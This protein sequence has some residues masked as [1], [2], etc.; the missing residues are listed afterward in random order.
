MSGGVL[1]SG[2][3]SLSNGRPPDIY[4]MSSGRMPSEEEDR[5]F[6]CT[7]LGGHIV[8]EYPDG[9]PTDDVDDIFR[10]SRL[11]VDNTILST[12]VTEGV[13]LSCVLDY[14]RTDS[15]E[16]ALAPYD[17]AP[18]V[19]PKVDRATITDLM[20]VVPYLRYAIRDLNQGLLH[21]EDSPVYFYRAIE[22]LARSIS[23]SYAELTPADWGRLHE[24]LGTSRDQLSVLENLTKSHRHGSRVRFSRDQHL[25]MMSA[26]RSFLVRAIEYLDKHPELHDSPRRTA[27]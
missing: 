7:I 16:V 19:E 20:A 5:R 2:K 12:V 13:G 24:A 10:V 22:A 15:G 21:R 3:I 18:A 25:Q 14:C 17:K 8:V 4:I 23:R 27:E 9:A 26:T 1:V 11:L 6:K